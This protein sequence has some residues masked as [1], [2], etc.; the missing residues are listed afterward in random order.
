M[1]ACGLA[2]PILAVP[3]LQRRRL[4]VAAAALAVAGAAFG[5][6]RAR[7][8]LGVAAGYA[9]K[10]VAS[11]VFVS[12]RTPASLL[13][14]ELGPVTPLERRFASLLDVE[15]DAAARAVRV[16]A[17]GVVRR[18]AVCREGLGCSLAL[19]VT[20]ADLH[21]QGRRAGPLRNPPAEA[22]PWPGGVGGL[23]P[24][25]LDP[26]RLERAVAAAFAAG[27]P[28]AGP[29]ALVVVHRGQLVAERYAPGYGPETPLPGWSMSKS[30]T[31]MLVGILVGR[32]TL[33]LED[34]VGL[35]EWEAD[36]RRRI[37]L[38]DLLQMSSGLDFDER[39]DGA[40]T[41]PSE[42]LFAS[43]DAAGFATRR[44]LRAE[45]GSRWSYS[46]G[47]TNVLCLLMRRAFG[48]DEAYWHFPREALF[49][50]IGA[51]SA[52]LETDPSGTFVGSSFL[53]A[54]ARDWARLGLLLL[55]DGVWRGERV[56]PGGW[57]VWLRQPA[58]AAP[59]GRYGAHLW[60]NAGSGPDGADRPF[61]ELPRDLFYF[62]GF[63]GQRVLVLPS[64]E[65]VV[66]RLGLTKDESVWS[67]ADILRPLLE[68][69]PEGP[70]SHA[71]PPWH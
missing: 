62:S 60:L 29:R 11:G 5:I 49:D 2:M 22:A 18:S 66:V 16:S 12:G 67:E 36:P 48:D 7:R 68:V 70:M 39:Y 65:L 4:L 26:G 13:A 51:H 56:L 30:V 37:R 40:L 1:V 53:Y 27:G 25:A 21:A 33:Q 54:S 45:P 50:R 64:H 52:V 57:A 10:Q 23:A 35:P 41:D 59:R 69:I 9:A 32:G 19:G 14:E 44:P 24:A 3:P 34:P 8:A 61:P 31:A 63:H 6:D 47:S 55:H 46:S 58:P 28:G 43:H 71:P 38:I 42:M 20:A 15:V 17:A